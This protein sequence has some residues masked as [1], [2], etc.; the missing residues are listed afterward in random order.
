MASPAT[1]ADVLANA[2]LSLAT[3]G[4]SQ[5]SDELA[6]TNL[7]AEHLPTILQHLETAKEDVKV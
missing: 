6:N 2:I 7:S 4:Y 5:S 1:D 3:E